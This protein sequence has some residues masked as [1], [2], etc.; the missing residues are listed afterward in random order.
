MIFNLP[1]KTYNFIGNEH[2]ERYMLKSILNNKL[3][4]AYIFSG[5]KGIGKATFAYRLSRYILS[6]SSKDNLFIE[7]SDKNSSLIENNSHPDFKVMEIDLDGGKKNIDI[8]QVRKCINFFNHTSSMSQ[9]KICIIDCIDDMNDNSSNAILKILE[10]P[11]INSIF[12]IISHN[13]ESVMPTIKSRCINLKFNKIKDE[14][15]KK[16]FVENDIG[17][18]SEELKRIIDLSKGSLGKC[19]Q[20]L[21]EDYNDINVKVERLFYHDKDLNIYDLCNEIKNDNYLT[22]FFELIISYFEDRIKKV[23]IKR[24]FNNRKVIFDFLKF[25]DDINNIIYEGQYY[26]NVKNHIIIDLCL[27][28]KKSNK[29][30]STI[31]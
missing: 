5:I 18:A 12:L 10:E 7:S 8:D 24:N 28:I 31:Q 22:V 25:R 16:Y 11:P 6:N 17:V 21:D 13:L 19:L 3:H 26:N 2:I 20:L 4:H 23:S 29:I 15:I 14:E 1:K 27:I 9:K 30:Y